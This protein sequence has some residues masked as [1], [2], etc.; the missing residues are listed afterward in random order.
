MKIYW[1][2]RLRG[3]LKHVDEVSD[4]VEFCNVKSYEVNNL[5]QKVLSK[6]IRNRL[7]DFLGI[8]QI[9]TISDKKCD[10]YASFNRFVK[11]DK[12]Y[13]I[14]LEN[15]TALYHYSLNRIKFPLGKKRYFE[16]INDKFFRGFICMS[17]KCRDTYEEINGL[18]PEHISLKTIYPLVPNNTNV[19]KD[20]IV[21]KSH[22]D[23]IELLY[24]VQGVRFVSKG[25]LEVLEAVDG[26]GDVH[27]TIITK[28]SDLDSRTLAK[29]REVK[30]V[31]L[32]DFD[33]SYSELEEVYAKTNILLQ[34]TSDDSFGL[35]IL[36]AMKGGCAIISSCLYSIPELVT[37]GENGLLFD[38]KYW[39]FNKEGIPN[40]KVWN[41]RKRTILSRKI[42]TRLVNEI[43]DGIEKLKN[44]REL[45]CSFCLSSYSKAIDD[46]LFGENGIKK[47][48]ED[49][50]FQIKE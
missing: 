27:L 20:I 28:I 45:L 18:L 21:K 49:Y 26:M 16:C 48:W 31:S 29:I 40:P 17:Q 38:P 42:N 37:D 12:P 6:I 30:N 47:Q 23:V 14:Y 50:V 33:Y 1:V 24:C 34:P 32:H 3:F 13:F 15:P 19:D 10:C 4:K 36:E 22:N 11:V 7:F 43:K 44:D 35:T 2:T 8:F 5:K 9:S 25:G 39:F 46:S 41:H